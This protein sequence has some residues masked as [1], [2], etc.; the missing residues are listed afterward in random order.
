M[1]L[2]FQ[3]ACVISEVI[4]KLYQKLFTSRKG[5]GKGFKTNG[6]K[7]S[8]ILQSTSAIAISI[9]LILNDISMRLSYISKLCDMRFVTFIQHWRYPNLN[10]LSK[11]IYLLIQ[12]TLI[13]LKIP[14]TRNRYYTFSDQS[15]VCLTINP[16]GLASHFF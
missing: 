11:N 2:V 8:V 16:N 10:Y 14:Y 6:G 13:E 15:D 9:T 5:K 12:V 3:I 1:F 4:L 7:L